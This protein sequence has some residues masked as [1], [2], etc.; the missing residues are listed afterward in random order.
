MK[1]SIGRII[2]TMG[3]IASNGTDEHPAIITRVWDKRDTAIDGTTMV[4]CT[5]LPDL[6]SIPAVGQGSIT[7]YDTRAEAEAEQ[8]RANAIGDNRAN[9]KQRG[10]SGPMVAFWPDRV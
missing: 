9:F 3:V 5:V 8:E 10:L 6:H 7:V 1:A 2:I 4:N